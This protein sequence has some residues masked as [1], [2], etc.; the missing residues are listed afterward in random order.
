M[1][2]CT[3]ISPLF[4]SLSSPVTYQLLQNCIQLINWVSRN[5]R[6][7]L[8]GCI[9]DGII[10]ISPFQRDYSLQFSCAG[11]G[12]E[13]GFWLERQQ[14]ATV[15]RGRKYFELKDAV[16]LL[17]AFKS[18]VWKSHRYRNMYNKLGLLSESN[19][20]SPNFFAAQ[21]SL[22]SGSQRAPKIVVLSS[23]LQS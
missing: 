9:L 23:S 6:L 5:N 20:V 19:H 13:N 12:G 21:M 3:N 10:R 17:E 4:L 18:L 14:E 11:V 22:S 2:H 16:K 15:V 7:E 1:L 8:G